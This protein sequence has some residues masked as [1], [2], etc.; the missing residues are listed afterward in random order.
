MCTYLHL[1]LYLL[2][3]TNYLS[4]RLALGTTLGLTSQLSP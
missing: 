1:C 3:V 4:G 2:T